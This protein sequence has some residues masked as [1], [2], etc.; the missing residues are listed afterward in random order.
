[1]DGTAHS[2]GIASRIGVRHGV[3][4]HDTVLGH[5][6]ID[7]VEQATVTSGVVENERSLSVIQVNCPVSGSCRVG[8]FFA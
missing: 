4:R 5:K 3:G 2:C 7:V 8:L 6:I 1:M